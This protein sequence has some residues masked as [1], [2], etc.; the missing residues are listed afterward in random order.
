M[1]F[2]L[3]KTDEL[4]ISRTFKITKKSFIAKFSSLKMGGYYKY[5]LNFLDNQWEKAFLFHDVLQT[6]YGL[7]FFYDLFLTV[8]N[9]Y[10][11]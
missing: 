11:K 3:L 9:I 8:L 5:S 1:Y 10:L 6:F 2:L 7:T 4:K